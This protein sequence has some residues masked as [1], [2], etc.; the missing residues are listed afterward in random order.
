M[1]A[2]AENS[3]TVSKRRRRRRRKF[4]DPRPDATLEKMR[5]QRS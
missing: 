4:E 1:L 3:D 5:L 2:E